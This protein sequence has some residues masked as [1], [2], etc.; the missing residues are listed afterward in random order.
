MSKQVLKYYVKSSQLFD[1]I[2]NGL[3]TSAVLS[4]R[5]KALDKIQF[6]TQKSNNSKSKMMGKV[7]LLVLATGEN[8]A[9]NVSEAS[10][11]T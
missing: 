6:R 3:V 4:N 11:L 10:S 7:L 5:I 9:R 1:S 2:V 8:S